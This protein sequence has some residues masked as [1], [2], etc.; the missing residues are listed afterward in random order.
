LAVHRA[1]LLP[2]GDKPD[3][4]KVDFMLGLLQKHTPQEIAVFYGS[5]T[6]EE[7]LVMEAAAHSV[8]RVPIK[9]ASGLE[10]APLLNPETVSE[11]IIAR[12]TATNPQG[13]KK[14]QELTEIRSMHV[15]VAG[16]A[17]AEIKEAL[18]D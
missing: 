17:A 2:T 11:S 1:A 3:A 7:R 13:A 12:A 5:A 4:R 15:S 8:G 16:I 6:D 9:T 10:W 18:S 14:L